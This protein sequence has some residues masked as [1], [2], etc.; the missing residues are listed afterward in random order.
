MM[1]ASGE[2]VVMDFGLAKRVADVDPNEAKLTRE[3]GLLGTPS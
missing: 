1:A 3:G 2:P